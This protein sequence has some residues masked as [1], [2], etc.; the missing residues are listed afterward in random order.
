MTVHVLA[1]APL[2]VSSGLANY[3]RKANRQRRCPTNR[4]IRNDLQIQ[5]NSQ[6]RNRLLI[7]ATDRLGCGDW[8]KWADWMASGHPGL[9]RIEKAFHQLGL[10]IRSILRIMR[11]VGRMNRP[12]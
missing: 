11:K 5:Q 2:A 12:L 1:C 4:S 10:H 6:G 9:R 7:R 3:E 8:K